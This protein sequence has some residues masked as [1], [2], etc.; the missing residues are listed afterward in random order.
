[1]HELPATEGILAAALEA[2]HAAGAERVVA[3]HLVVGDLTSIVDDSIQFYFDILGRG[4][5]AAGAVLQFRRVSPRCRCGEC[6]STFDVSP[7]LPRSCEEC[8]SLALVVTGGQEFYVESIEVAD[9]G[10]GSDADPEGERR[11]GAGEP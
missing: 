8:G 10:P 3:I 11:G 7:P 2:A 6:G 9:E 4:T 1:M 5:A